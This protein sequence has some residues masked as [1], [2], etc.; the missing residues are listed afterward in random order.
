MEMEVRILACNTDVFLMHTYY[1]FLSA[2]NTVDILMCV[3]ILSKYCQYYAFLVNTVVKN[4]NL[5]LTRILFC[6]FDIFFD[7]Y[8]PFQLNL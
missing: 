8:G 6:F 3:K 2:H 1:V 7:R 4:I 5:T